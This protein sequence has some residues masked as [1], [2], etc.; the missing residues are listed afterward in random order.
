MNP[1]PMPPPTRP[2]CGRQRPGAALVVMGVFEAVAWSIML[3]SMFGAT[4]L[5]V[6]W[7]C[8]VAVCAGV[9]FCMER[10]GMTL[11]DLA[12]VMT[13]ALLALAWILMGVFAFL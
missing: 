2:G 7:P 12:R 10:L 5:I 11:G 13:G 4:G 6:G 1:R 9:A 3:V 8:T